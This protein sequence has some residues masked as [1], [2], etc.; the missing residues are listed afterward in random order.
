MYIIIQ[1]ALWLYGP[2]KE[3]TEVGAMNLFCFFDHGGNRR[4]L[5]TSGLESGLVLPGITR[6]SVLEL[7]R[8]WGEFE[9]NER[10]LTMDEVLAG[11]SNGTLVEMF[12]TGTFLCNFVKF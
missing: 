5:V 6:K 9:V 10:K 11:A 3:I 4:E 12:G 1:Q 8:Q 2:E 7:A